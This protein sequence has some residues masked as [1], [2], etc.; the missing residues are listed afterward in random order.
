MKQRIFAILTLILFLFA[1]SMLVSDIC[2]AKTV[3][4]TKD[5][6]T[7]S[8]ALKAGVPTIVKF[9]SDNCP[10]CRRMKP[11]MK[12]LAVE[13]DGKVIFLDLDVYENRELANQMEVRVIPTILYYDKRG[14]LKKK[15]EGGMT[16]DEL[17]RAIDILGLRK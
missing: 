2:Q 14:K 4:S 11:I 3:R 9:G 7:L 5:I 16:K 13:Q 10:P 12:E 8:A 1:A 6:K 17:L 15:S